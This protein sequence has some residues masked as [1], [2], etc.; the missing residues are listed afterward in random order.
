MLSGSSFF[1][2]STQFR[3]NPKKCLFV[4]K[5]ELEILGLSSSQSQ[6][7]SFALVLGERNGDRRLPIIIGGFEA[8]AIA[9]EMENVKPNRPMTHD[10]FVSLFEHF[11][12]DLVE[13][14]I[15]DLQDGV[16]FAQLI[17]EHNGVQKAIDSRP[18]DAIAIAV[19]LDVPVFSTEQILKEAGIV[20]QEDEDG[21]PR[22]RKTQPTPKAP[23][24]SEIPAVSTELTQEDIASLSELDKV[25]LIRKLNDEM[26]AAINDED[27]E[28]AAKIRD[29][30]NRLEQNS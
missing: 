12:I 14:Q 15:T 9:L 4:E 28:K 24:P 1:L 23:K 26:Q 10:L 22:P 18:S 2:I 3:L 30:V 17:I 5:I 6:I 27:Y 21:N 13:V 7:G 8:Q 16:F 11:N 20:I 29:Q 19:R 25:K